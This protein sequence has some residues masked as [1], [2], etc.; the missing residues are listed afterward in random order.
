MLPTIEDMVILI[1]KRNI[2]IRPVANH[3]TIAYAGKQLM[4]NPNMSLI[5]PMQPNMQENKNANV[6]MMENAV[7]NQFYQDKTRKSVGGLMAAG[8]SKRKENAYN[9]ITMDQ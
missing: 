1:V 6:S 7:D 3:S 8:L 2:M 5:S 4:Q 9:I